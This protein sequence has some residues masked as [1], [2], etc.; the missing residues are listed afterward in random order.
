MSDAKNRRTHIG[1]QPLHAETQMLSY[2]FD[3]FLSEGAVKPPVFL[4]ST[5]AFRT[6]EEGAAFFDIAAGRAPAPEGDRGGLVYGRLN[7]PN[8][9]IAEE[10]LALLDGAEAALITSSGM[11]A[12]SALFFSLLRPGQQIVRSR[13]LYGGTETLINQVMPEWGVSSVAFDD[14]MSQAQ[15]RAA[16]ETAAGR[17]RVGLFYIETP[18]NP[19]NALVDFAAVDSTLAAFSARHGY[20][21]PSV[22]DNTLLGPLF[23]QPLQHGIDM[24]VYSLTKY[25]GGHSDLIAGGVTG[26]RAQI[27]TLRAWRT[28][29]GCQLDAHS[30]WLLGRSMETLALRMRR[31]ADSASRVAQWLA[32]EAPQPLTVLHPEHIDD[33]RY[34]EVYARQCSAPGSTFSLVL[35]G[36]RAAAFR[37]VNAL[38]LFKLAVSL[39]GTESLVCHPASTTHSGVAPE[40][41]AQ[42]GVVEG[43]V[44]LSVGLE[45][46]DDLIADLD[47]ALQKV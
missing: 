28:A 26:P 27:D 24:V 12:I 41:R 14:G 44:R 22:C 9:Q 42:A 19:V 37:F 40:V 15:M 4:T 33:A 32:T 2:G 45:H 21:P 13:S 43:L 7:H 31:A 30:S 3:P 17:G 20:R 1:E 10:R 29:V 18:A 47:Q 23:Q 6:A 35:E 38:T 25:V 34:S 8:L 39:G 11:A 16:L 36:G 5:F 46:A